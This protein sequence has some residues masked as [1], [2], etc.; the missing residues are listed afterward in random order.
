MPEWFTTYTSIQANSPD[1][2]LIRKKCERSLKS[3]EFIGANGTSIMCVFYVKTYHNDSTYNTVSTLYDHKLY[4]FS[5]P[6]K[7]EGRGRGVSSTTNDSIVSWG[8]GHCSYLL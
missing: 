8:Q 2:G 6:P 7:N 1:I 3:H 5:V 4:L